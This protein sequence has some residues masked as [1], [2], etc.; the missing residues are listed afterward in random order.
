LLQSRPLVAWHLPKPAPVLL[1]EVQPASARSLVPQLAYSIGHLMCWQEPELV[2]AEAAV[3]R[4][5][6]ETSAQ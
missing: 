6:A 3:A 4:Q 1:P 2:A 5:A